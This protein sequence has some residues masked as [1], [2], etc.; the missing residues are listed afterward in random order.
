VIRI[1]I[2]IRYGEM[3]TM[4]FLLFRNCPINSFYIFI[5]L[6]LECYQYVL[7][8][9]SYMY[10]TME[11]LHLCSLFLLFWTF[12]FFFFAYFLFSS[13]LLNLLSI[14]SARSIIGP[15]I[16]VSGEFH[17]FLQLLCIDFV[18]IIPITI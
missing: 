2:Y 12:L 6:I 4:L 7:N 17:Q 10:G 8:I 3:D 1:Q 9:A 18:N 13:H 5:S 15:L 16:S 14:C 11:S